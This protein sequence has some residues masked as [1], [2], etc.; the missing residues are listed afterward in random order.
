MSKD[1]DFSK[2]EIGNFGEDFVINK[3]QKDGFKI[4]EKNY[5]KKFGEIDIIAS[6]QNLIAFIEV[7]TRKSIYFD[8]S[9][10]IVSSKQKKIIMTAKEY[11]CSKNLYDHIFRFDVALVECKN[12]K[13]EI[14]YFENAFTD[15]FTY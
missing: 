8:L 9:Q 3:L 13:F 6:K 15:E 5:R 12:N 11:L 4:L 2:K 10:V 7:K 14:K 1:F